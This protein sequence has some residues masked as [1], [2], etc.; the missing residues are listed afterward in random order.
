MTTPT[1]ELSQQLTKAKGGLSKVT[2]GLIA[3]IALVLA[4]GGGVLVQKAWG[5]S[6]TTAADPGANG[7]RFPRNGNGT[8]TPPSGAP[9][10]GRGG[11]GTTGTIDHIDGGTVYVKQP[12]GT[13][14]KVTTS[15]TTQ[16]SKTAVGKVSDLKA[17][18][19]IVIQGQKSGDGTVTAQRIT[20]RPA[21]TG[22]P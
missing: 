10:F 9:G 7:Q 19:T 5:S 8:G 4:F 16:V 3:A 14:V 15:D 20:E 12:D 21:G 18:E 13:V 22:G 17:G 11:A 6:T 1:D 2:I